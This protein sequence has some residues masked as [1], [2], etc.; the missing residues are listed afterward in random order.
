MP[1][2]IIFLGMILTRAIAAGRTGVV[3]SADAG[4]SLTP[5]LTLRRYFD[6]INFGS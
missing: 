6:E 4:Q 2:R 5:T 1:G 3:D